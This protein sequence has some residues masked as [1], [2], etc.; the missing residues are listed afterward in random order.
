MVQ[1]AVAEALHAG[2]DMPIQSMAAEAGI[3]ASSHP[4]QVPSR[5]LGARA[6]A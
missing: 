6:G 3:E 1:F 4:L 5:W 2:A